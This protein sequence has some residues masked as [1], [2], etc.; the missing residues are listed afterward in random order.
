MMVKGVL[1][2]LILAYRLIPCRI[3]R[4]W[5]FGYSTSHLGLAV[6]RDAG[7]GLEAARAFL[8][9][10]SPSQLVMAL[11]QPKPSWGG[12]DFNNTW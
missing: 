12:N 4:L 10:V 3:R 5:S 2:M 11:G 6:V 9:Y 1:I 8:V 7:T